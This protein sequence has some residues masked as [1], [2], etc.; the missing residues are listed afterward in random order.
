MTESWVH[1]KDKSMI[2]RYVCVS[3]LKLVNGVFFVLHLFEVTH[4]FSLIRHVY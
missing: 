4:S 3:V 1:H 2:D